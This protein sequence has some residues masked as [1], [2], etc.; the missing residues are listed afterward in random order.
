MDMT[1]E[2]KEMIVRRVEEMA[3]KFNKLAEELAIKEDVATKLKDQHQELVK[4]NQELISDKVKLRNE[5]A[6]LREQLKEKLAKKDDIIAR[7]RHDIM[8][9]EQN[10]YD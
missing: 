6:I 3:M 4:V 9:C 7:L 5:V 10:T 8:L 1:D 2:R